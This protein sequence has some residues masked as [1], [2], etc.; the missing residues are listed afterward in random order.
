ML[1]H[2][3]LRYYVLQ[4]PVFV[5]QVLLILSFVQYRPPSYGNYS[6][7]GLAEAMG[8]CLAVFVI[9]PVFIVLL[10]NIVKNRGALEKVRE[11]IGLVPSVLSYEITKHS[12]FIV[13]QLMTTVSVV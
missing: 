12:I 4:I 6:F 8:W 5:F 3:I 2:N 10:I 11:T 1:T 7:P 13:L 9:S